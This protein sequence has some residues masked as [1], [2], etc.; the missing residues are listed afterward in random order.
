MRY[1]HLSVRLDEDSRA[2]LLDTDSGDAEVLGHLIESCDGLGNEVNFA[3]FSEHLAQSPFAEIYAGVRA[4]VLREEIDEEPATQEFDAAITK[5]LAE[6]LSL[7]L[8]RLQ[9][10]VSAGTADDAEKIRMI[11]LV[12]EIQRRRQLG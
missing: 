8:D 6:P 5:L 4:A 10:A 2:L 9:A 12:G 1:P 11:W 3:A 7:E